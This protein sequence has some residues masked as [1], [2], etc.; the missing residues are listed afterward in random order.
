MKIFLIRH[1]EQKY[2]RD[3]QGKKIVSTLDAP[4]VELG[5]TQIRQLGRQ[6]AKEGQVLDA[7]YTSPVLRAR[8]STEVLA[9]ELEVSDTYVVDDLKEG[10]PNSAEGKTYEELEVI[11]GD[12]YAH[13]FSPDQEILSHLV[14]RTR[15]AVNFILSDARRRGFNSVGIV[16]HGDPLCALE[17]SLKHPDNPASYDKMKEFYYPQKGQALE[18]TITDDEP[19]GLVGEGRIITTEAAKQTI[20]G[21]RNSTQKEAE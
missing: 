16:G 13:P 11:G 2:P 1:G 6:L 21:F 20:E 19:F 18:Y 9:R 17:W 8:Q 4:L 12:I 14:E 3:E 15:N 7:I 10:F 5:K